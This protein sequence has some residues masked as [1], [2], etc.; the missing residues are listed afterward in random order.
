MKNPYES[1]PPQHFWKPGVA[2]RP[3]GEIRP[4]PAKRFRLE[5]ADRI[6]TAG[7]CFAQHVSAHIRKQ[8]FARFLQTETVGP[9]AVHALLS[10][11][12]VFVFTLGLT[13]AWISLRD[14]TAYPLAP[15]VVAAPSEPAQYGFRNFTYE[16]VCGDL[17]SFV[18]RLQ[19]LNPRARI[20]PTV[21]PVPL[22]ATYTDEHVLIATMHSK[23]ILRAVCSAITARYEHVYYFPAYEIVA[24][25]Q[26]R[27]AYF[28]DNL[29]NVTSEGVAQVMSVFEE[30]YA[31]ASPDAARAHSGS[32]AARLFPKSDE[33]VLCDEADIV[34]TL[35]F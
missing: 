22:T 12:T 16:Q 29:R 30:T 8:G 32:A 19:S 7:S 14:G 34:K 18:T 27:G 11:C 1:R 20:L 9:A 25:H 24:G 31:V 26:T 35:G 5:P 23:S 15:G 21:S 3:L 6:A 13:E 33:D 2:E 4:V 17:E 10:E 28:T